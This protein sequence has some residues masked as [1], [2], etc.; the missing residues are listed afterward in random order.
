MS[1]ICYNLSI[2][3]NLSILFIYSLFGLTSGVGVIIIITYDGVVLTLIT[4]M[5]DLRLKVLVDT[6]SRNHVAN[7]HNIIHSG[8]ILQ[9]NT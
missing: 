2:F 3:Y 5:V 7:R 6:M 9:Q 8:I 4:Y 1:T